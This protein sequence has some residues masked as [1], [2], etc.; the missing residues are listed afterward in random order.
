MSN[1]RNSTS[2][3][4]ETKTVAVTTGKLFLLL[5]LQIFVLATF[6]NLSVAGYD[7]VTIIEKV[8][9]VIDL[10]TPATCQLNRQHMPTATTPGNSSHQLEEKDVKPFKKPQS[11]N[12]VIC[13]ICAE[14]SVG[15]NPTATIC[16]H[17]FCCVCIRRAIISNKRCPTC[18]KFITSANCF[19]L[20]IWWWWSFAL[21][22]FIFIL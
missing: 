19:P 12:C 9:P 3:P 11:K 10:C 7:D 6:S 8:I 5:K 15:R 18:K 21:N 20:Y 22:L 2:V 1:W 13:A 16:G 14:S 4:N 17:V